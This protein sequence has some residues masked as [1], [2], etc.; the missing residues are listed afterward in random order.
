MGSQRLQIT[1][2]E[3]L[4]KSTEDGSTL[5]VTFNLKDKDG[6]QILTYKTAQNLAMFPENAD[7]D[8]EKV[9]KHL[10]VPEKEWR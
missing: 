8:V 9:L 5:L 7:K 4:R 3:E 6:Q 1:K 10:G 2:I